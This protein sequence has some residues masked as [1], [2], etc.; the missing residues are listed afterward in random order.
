LGEIERYACQNVNK[1]LVGNK[2]DL[3]KAVDTNEAKEFANSLGITFKETSAKSSTNVSETFYT[4]TKQIKDR[5][6]ASQPQASNKANNIEINRNSTKV[7]KKKGFF[8]SC[9]IV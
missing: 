3:P 2:C 1:L 5:V 4:M 7:S 6:T 9:V 8:S